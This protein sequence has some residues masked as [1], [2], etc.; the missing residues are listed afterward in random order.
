MLLFHYRSGIEREFAAAIQPTCFCCYTNDETR[1][2][3]NQTSQKQFDLMSTRRW[4]VY[5]Y[6]HSVANMTDDGWE[7]DRILFFLL[8]E[9]LS[10]DIFSVYVSRAIRFDL[11]N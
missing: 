3:S 11:S 10:I 5:Y 2:T 4:G 8:S 9:P 6:F 1:E 7:R